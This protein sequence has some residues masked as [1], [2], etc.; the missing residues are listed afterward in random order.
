[1]RALSG[2]RPE[3]ELL[4]PGA[5]VRS[6]HKAVRLLDL[7]RE[8]AEERYRKKLEQSRRLD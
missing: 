2:I 1:V 6:P 8:G 5:L 3:V 4:E 7:R